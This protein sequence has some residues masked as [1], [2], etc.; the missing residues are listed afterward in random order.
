MSTRASVRIIDENSKE[1]KWAYHHTNGHPEFLGLMIAIQLSKLRWDEWKVENIL[2]LL[3]EKEIQHPY[4]SYTTI[5]KPTCG[6]G[7]ESFVYS[8]NCNLRTLTCYNHCFNEDYKT[9]MKRDR[10]EMFIRI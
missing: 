9:C 2:K 5:L 8:I 6:A 1:E 3:T 7:D 10:I 4:M